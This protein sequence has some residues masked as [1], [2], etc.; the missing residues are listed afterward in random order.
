MDKDPATFL[1]TYDGAQPGYEKVFI[2]F[3]FSRPF[4]FRRVVATTPDPANFMDIDVSFLSLIT[5]NDLH[6]LLTQLTIGYEGVEVMTTHITLSTNKLCARKRG[7]LSYPRV[8]FDCS[9][10][11]DGTYVVLQKVVGQGSLHLGEIEFFVNA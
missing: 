10:G 2:Q 11:L 4:V 9:T 8:T 3:K 1:A 7:L 6:R 5:L